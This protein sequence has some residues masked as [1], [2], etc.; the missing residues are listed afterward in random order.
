MQNAVIWFK[1]LI[2]KLFPPKKGKPEL[3]LIIACSE[4]PI[5]GDKGIEVLLRNKGFLG[6]FSMMT[7]HGSTFGYNRTKDSRHEIIKS[8]IE[9]GDYA[10]IIVI[11][12]EDC[13]C[14]KENFP[15]FLPEILQQIQLGNLMRFIDEASTHKKGELIAL[16]LNR[17]G[18]IEDAEKYIDTILGKDEDIKKK[19]HSEKILVPC[20]I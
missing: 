13:Q 12:H 4:L 7:L 8:H 11:E 6:G 17:E 9:S 19:K 3:N 20:C 18:I 2:N 5:Y 14:Y 15:E 16:I 10:K 1:A